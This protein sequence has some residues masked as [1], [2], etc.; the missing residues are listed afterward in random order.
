MTATGIDP[1][2][3][4]SSV[5]VQALID[6]AVGN[7]LVL[8]VFP[9]RGGSAAVGAS[10]IYLMRLPRVVTPMTLSWAE[11]FCSVAAG[12]VAVGLMTTTDA[13][14]TEAQ[15]LAATYT[16]VA[17]TGAV[18]AAGVN[19]HQRL[20]FAAPYNYLPDT[21][22]WVAFGGDTGTLQVG[23]AASV[24]ALFTRRADAIIKSAGYSSGIPSTLTTL[25]AA[26]AFQPYL[27]VG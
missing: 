24:G 11:Y 23:R 17:H 25:A 21:N 3:G 16:R 12:N 7:P 6:A 27:A 19:V 18:A 13:F 22:L 14:E 8:E 15:A 9:A 2:S 4:Q 5:Q 20:T 26:G 10:V 1:R